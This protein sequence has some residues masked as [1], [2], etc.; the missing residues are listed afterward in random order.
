MIYSPPLTMGIVCAADRFVR[1]SKEIFNFKSFMD[2]METNQSLGLAPM[3]SAAQVTPTSPEILA[4]EIPEGRRGVTAGAVGN[5]A[6]LPIIVVR[7]HR[8]TITILRK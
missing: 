5:W 6:L 2:P 3:G 8:R 4:A 7:L 1:A